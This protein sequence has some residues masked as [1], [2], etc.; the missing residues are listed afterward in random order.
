MTSRR[1]AYH[2]LKRGLQHVETSIEQPDPAVLRRIRSLVGQYPGAWAE[3]LKRAKLPAAR[4]KWIEQWI[5]PREK[6]DVDTIPELF[7]GPR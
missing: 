2:A 5:P 7:G 1:A 3:V 4:M 6:A